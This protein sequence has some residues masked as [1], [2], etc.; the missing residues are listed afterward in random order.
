MS[1]IGEG[2]SVQSSVGRVDAS[3]QS[4]L[5]AGIVDEAKIGNDHVAGVSFRRRR[6]RGER[7]SWGT[8]GQDEEEK[9]YTKLDCLK[10][11]WAC[12]DKWTC[13]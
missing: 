2:V 9:N 6:R 8:S 1:Q 10:R 3:S 12:E 7:N 13:V 5:I 4:Q 11:S